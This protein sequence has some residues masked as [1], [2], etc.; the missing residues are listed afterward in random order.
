MVYAHKHAQPVQPLHFLPSEIAQIA[1]VKTDVRARLR[2]AAHYSPVPLIFAWRT[3][4]IE[5][6]SDANRRFAVKC[7]GYGQ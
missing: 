2:F 4:R 3:S 7:A 5:F 6:H 1:V